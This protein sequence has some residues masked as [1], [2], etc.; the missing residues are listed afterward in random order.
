[1][2]C[3]EGVSAGKSGCSRDRSEGSNN[4]ALLYV[5]SSVWIGGS[6]GSRRGLVG[7]VGLVFIGDSRLGGLVIFFWEEEPN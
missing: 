6:C 5:L 4:N 1:M 2:R 7:G 3:R